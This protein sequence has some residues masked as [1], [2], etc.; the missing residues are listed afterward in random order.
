VNTSLR[1]GDA[2]SPM[3]FNL[4]LEKLVREMNISERSALDQ[5]TIKLLAYANDIAL[6]R[7]NIEMIKCLGKKLVNIAKKEGLTVNDDKTECV[8]VN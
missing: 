3:F 7:N 1:Q 2:H 6:L 5:S 4:V 8:I